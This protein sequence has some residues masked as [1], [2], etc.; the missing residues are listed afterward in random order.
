M[1]ELCCFIPVLLEQISCDVNIRNPCLRMTADQEGFDYRPYVL[2]CCPS[3]QVLDGCVIGDGER[4]QAQWLYR[5]GHIQQVCPGQHLQLV[6]YLATVCPLA[7]QLQTA[8]DAQIPHIVSKQ[9]HHHYLPKYRSKQSYQLPHGETDDGQSISSLLDSE[10][11]YVPLTTGTPAKAGAVSDPCQPCVHG[12]TASQ[13]LPTH[14][15]FIEDSTQT[16]NKLTQQEQ[17]QVSPLKTEG[18]KDKFHPTFSVYLPHCSLVKPHHHTQHQTLATA[19][20]EDYDMN[21]G[22][23]SRVIPDP[24]FE[25]APCVNLIREVADHRRLSK[26][27]KMRENASPIPLSHSGQSAAKSSRMRVKRLDSNRQA[28]LSKL[29]KCQQNA[30]RS[31][32]RQDRH[33]I[34]PN[35]TRIWGQ[36]GHRAATVI[37]AMWRGYR[38]RE[39]NM[40]VI[41]VRKEI[42]ARRA[43]DHIVLLRAELDRLKKLYHEEKRLRTLQMEAIRR[44]YNEVQQLKSQMQNPQ[45]GCTNK[46]GQPSTLDSFEVTG[47]QQSGMVSVGPGCG[48][49]LYFID[50]QR[51]AELERKC[52]TLQSQVSQLQEV[53]QSMSLTRHEGLDH[54]SHCTAD[55]ELVHTVHVMEYILDDHSQPASIDTHGSSC[56][57]SSIPH[58]LSPYPSEEEELYFRQVPHDGAPTRPRNLSLRH[59][60]EHSVVLHWLPSQVLQQSSVYLKSPITGYKIYINDRLKGEM[61]GRKTCALVTGLNTSETYKFYV[62]GVSNEEESFASNIVMARLARGQPIAVSSDS[63]MPSDSDKDEDSVEGQDKR[64]LRKRDSRKHRKVRSPRSEKKLPK[65]SLEKTLVEE[66][67]AA[68]PTENQKTCDILTQPKVHKH[69]RTNSKEQGELSCLPKASGVQ[70]ISSQ[71]S[72]GPHT[73]EIARTSSAAS[74]SSSAASQSSSPRHHPSSPVGGEGKW[75]AH[76]G[77]SGHLERRSSE[78]GTQGSDHKRDLPVPPMTTGTQSSLTETFTVDRMKSFLHKLGLPLTDIQASTTEGRATPESCSIKGHHYKGSR[79][80]TSPIHDMTGVH[81]ESPK[82]KTSPDKCQMDLKSTE[83]GNSV[84]ASHQTPSLESVTAHLVEEVHKEDMT[85]TSV[86]RTEGSSVGNKDRERCST[87][88]LDGRRRSRPTSPMVSEGAGVDQRDVEVSVPDRRRIPTAELLEQRLSA[89]KKSSSLTS[90]PEHEHEEMDNKAAAHNSK[91]SPTSDSLHDSSQ[92]DGSSRVSTHQR[93]HSFGSEADLTTAKSGRKEAGIASLLA[94]LQVITHSQEA[95]RRE[96]GTRL[97]RRSNEEDEKHKGTGRTRHISESDN[98]MSSDAGSSLPP[99]APISDSSSGS[100]SDDGKVLHTYHRTHRRSP[101]DQQRQV[102]CSDT[103]NSLPVH[104]PI[105]MEGRKQNTNVRRNA[106]FHALPSRPADSNLASQCTEASAS[107]SA[108]NSQC[109]EEITAPMTSSQMDDGGSTGRVPSPQESLG[110][111]RCSIRSRSP[112]PNRNRQPVLSAAQLKRQGETTGKSSS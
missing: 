49:G 25:S 85:P 61:S 6:R 73:R 55:T 88:V 32:Q 104:S 39:Y 36:E 94:K 45:N 76:T 59:Q 75:K 86:S 37:Q 57:W 83:E 47:M 69:R 10:S 106:S 96:T 84:H 35:Q 16:D 46:L 4:L 33:A 70:V 11:V 51:T 18:N 12:S 43:E 109:A 103:M 80:P 50:L 102:S 38:A 110:N 29:V 97:R 41:S 91:R 52:A 48:T 23:F 78:R 17:H 5:Q 87:P 9:L 63:D 2:C 82:D 77:S 13:T 15:S 71:A 99:R 1:E 21:L 24:E 72:S 101:S 112:S 74:Q 90:M 56:H 26:E 66:E 67:L 40:H 68:N 79:E 93:T 95:S 28:E 65:S 105:I 31:G 14:T 60:G 92:E 64:R 53:L 7:D 107:R 89:F 30:D 100:H 54:S 44:L 19:S 111:P 62:K 42:R 98:D 8:E 58:S 81:P 34:A 108:D 20:S 3:L 22:S 27:Q